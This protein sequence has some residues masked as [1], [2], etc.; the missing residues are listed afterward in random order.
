MI[1]IL[2]TNLKGG[3]GKTTIATNLAGAFAK[4]GFKTALADV[5]R[6][7][8]SLGWLELRPTTAA[9][10]HGLDWHKDAGEVRAASSVW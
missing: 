9:T 10:I 4:G 2:V 6:Q 1:R 5:D 7:R 3:C 8:S